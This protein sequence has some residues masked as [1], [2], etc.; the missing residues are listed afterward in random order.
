MVDRW[1]SSVNDKKSELLIIRSKNMKSL[2]LSLTLNDAAIPQVSTHKHL[3]LH[4]ND[5]LSWSNHVHEVCSSASRKIGSLRRLRL[6]LGPL[7]RQLY[8]S[9]IRPALEYAGIA[10]CGMSSTNSAHLEKV[11]RVAHLISNLPRTSNTDVPTT[12]SW[13]ERAFNL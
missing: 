13:R 9:S 2:S 10:W 8:C 4:I 11:R 1:H 3:G 6:R 12:S 5:L 7:I